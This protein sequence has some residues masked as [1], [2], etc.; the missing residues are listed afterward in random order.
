MDAGA[1]EI[2]NDIWNCIFGQ[3]TEGLDSQPAVDESLN[4]LPYPYCPRIFHRNLTTVFE[5]N[6]CGSLK[7]LRIKP[8]KDRTDIKNRPNLTGRKPLKLFKRR[9]EPALIQ[10]LVASSTSISSCK[11]KIPFSDYVRDLDLSFCKN[12]NIVQGRTVDFS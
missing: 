7:L 2:R 12:G 11:R 1:E 5:R 8:Y 9:Q 4:P 10:K 6:S 3:Q